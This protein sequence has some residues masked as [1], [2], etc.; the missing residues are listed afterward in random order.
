MLAWRLTSVGA[1]CRLTLHQ[2]LADEKMASA[3]AAGWHLCLAVAKSVL[4][5]KKVPPVRGAEAMDHGF[6]E[7]N[8]GYAAAL[9][10]APSELG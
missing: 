10:V 6:A 8:E 3:N 5:G 2:T 1:R 4:A 9:G 7:L